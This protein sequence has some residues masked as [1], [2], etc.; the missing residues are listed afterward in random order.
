MKTRLAETLPLLQDAVAQD[1]TALLHGL[2]EGV[3]P[4]VG[5]FAPLIDRLRLVER[6]D[7]HPP[8][9]VGAA[10]WPNAAYAYLYRPVPSPVFSLRTTPQGPFHR[11]V[12]N[13]LGSRPDRIDVFLQELGKA[14]LRWQDETVLVPE[15]YLNALGRETPDWPDRLRRFW[16]AVEDLARRA[17]GRRILT[18]PKE[19]T[20]PDTEEY[21]RFLRSLGFTPDPDEDGPWAKDLHQ[22]GGEP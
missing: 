1:A 9:Y 11:D 4:P 17:G 13:R 3:H 5:V 21:R 14:R 20:W 22:Y 8:L 7:D 12:E 16:Q 19:P 6:W 18:V 10:F 15:C 2:P